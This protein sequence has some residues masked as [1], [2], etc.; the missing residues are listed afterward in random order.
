[1]KIKKFI[2]LQIP[3]YGPYRP[4]APR[5][6][7][8]RHLPPP[9]KPTP[10]PTRPTPR[11]TRPTTTSTTPRPWTP[12]PTHPPRTPPPSHPEPPYPYPP[13]PKHPEITPEKPDTC[14]TSYDAISVIRNEVF[15]FKGKVSLSLNLKIYLI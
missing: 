12:R 10:P 6:E 8:P 14:N 2:I 1:M 15:I 9:T 3:H 7:P 5:A 4:E 13:S 11:P